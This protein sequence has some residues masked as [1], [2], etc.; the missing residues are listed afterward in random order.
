MNNR[1]GEDELT[2]IKR[3]L[4]V[5]CSTLGMV[6]I[7]L[8]L[9]TADKLLDPIKGRQELDLTGEK[10]SGFLK[11]MGNEISEICGLPAVPVEH[12]YSIFGNLLIPLVLVCLSLAIACFAFGHLL[13]T[14]IYSDD[15]WMNKVLSGMLAILYFAA[16]VLTARIAWSLFM[17]T[18]QLFI[19]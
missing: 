3:N 6:L 2:K 18:F 4:D 9:M 11:K 12:T 16:I 7:F 5:V 17:L 14:V 1:R 15:V 8:L 10:F 19:G 13:K